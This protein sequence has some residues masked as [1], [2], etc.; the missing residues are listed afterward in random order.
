VYGEFAAHS[1][2]KSKKS[3]VATNGCSKG[4]RWRNLGKKFQCLVLLHVA[5]DCITVSVL[6]YSCRRSDPQSGS[7]KSRNRW[8]LAIQPNRGSCG[9]LLHIANP[10]ISALSLE[11]REYTHI[12]EPKGEKS[13][14]TQRTNPFHAN[15]AREFVAYRRY[16]HFTLGT[17]TRSIGT[18]TESRRFQG[19]ALGDE[20]F[21]ASACATGARY[22]PST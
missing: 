6:T 13:R 11:Y 10:Y 4:S 12:L 9:V 17:Y 15:R 2:L 7:E 5:D 21:W 16:V 14:P 20:S 1:E 18:I 22:A 19:H 8:T 3:K